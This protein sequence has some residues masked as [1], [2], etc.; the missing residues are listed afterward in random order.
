VTRNTLL[1]LGVLLVGSAAWLVDATL[2]WPRAAFYERDLHRLDALLAA[3]MTFEVSVLEAHAGL[4]LS[5]DPINHALSSLRGAAAAAAELQARG[6]AYAPAADRVALAARAQDSEESSVE[7]FKTDLALLRLSSCHFPLAA[8][9]LIR[10]A[11]ADARRERRS[12]LA[13]E[14]ATLGALRTDMERLDELPAHEDV[15]RL[16]HGLSKLQTLRASLDDRGREELDML[17]GHTRAILDRR[18][19][20]DQLARTLVRSPVRAHLEA[21]RAAYERSS[22]RQAQKVGA[23][24]VLSAVLALTGVIVLAGVVLRSARARR[25]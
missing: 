1:V 22:R 23:L 18:E 24:Q 4:Q 16:E 10:R 14:L 6:A 5:F 19:R 13:G 9:A 20:V 7:Q 25:A 21:A 8:N 15:Q 17:S 11:E 2:L 3:R 12:L